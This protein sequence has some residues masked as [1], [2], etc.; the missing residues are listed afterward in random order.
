MTFN[1]LAGKRLLSAK[2]PQEIL[3]Y[4]SSEYLFKRVMVMLQ[5]SDETIYQICQF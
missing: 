4:F 5:T 3:E 2:L 1:E